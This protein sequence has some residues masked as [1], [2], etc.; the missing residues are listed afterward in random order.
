MMTCSTPRFTSARSTGASFIK[1]GRAPT[2]ERTRMVM[3][4]LHGDALCEVARAIHVAAAQDGDVIRE[5][6][7]R[8]HRQHRREEWCGDRHGDLV[9]GEMTEVVRPLA[10][11]RD[12]AAAA[13]LHLLHG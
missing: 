3:A 12:D 11:D 6:L 13:R 7:Q 5:E 4:S 1:F 10:R 9:I 2:T 8:D